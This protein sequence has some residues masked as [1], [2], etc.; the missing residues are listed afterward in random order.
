MVHRAGVGNHYL[1]VSDND[2]CLATIVIGLLTL[3]FARIPCF[4]KFNLD[5]TCSLGVIF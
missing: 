5:L 1:V 3:S 2:T 4:L